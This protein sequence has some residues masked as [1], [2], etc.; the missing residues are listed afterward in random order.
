[1][2]NTIDL[3]PGTNNSL[4]NVMKKYREIAG[5]SQ[6]ELADLIDVN[7][8]SVYNW[9]NGK[10][11]PDV[12]S[13]RKLCFSLHMPVQELLGITDNEEAPN[14]Q[15][16]ILL[17]QYRAMSQHTKA[18]ALKAMTAMADEDIRQQEQELIANYCVISIQNTHAAAGTGCTYIDDPELKHCFVRKNTKSRRADTLVVVSGRSMEPLYYDGDMIYVRYAS[19]GNENDVLVCSTADGMVVKKVDA[20]GRLYSVNPDLP[21]GKK[22]EDDNV[23]VLGRVIGVVDPEDIAS[24]QITS[25]L[26]ELLADEIDKL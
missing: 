8:N 23:H 2:S 11:T 24:E 5:L 22:Y 21:F 4:G 18:V 26:E 14:Q 17:S 12:D 16:L 15:E 1:M 10:R 7:R 6:A 13:I 20:E 9:E 19:G 25:T 3:F